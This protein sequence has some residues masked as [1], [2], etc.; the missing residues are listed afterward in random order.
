MWGVNPLAYPLYCRCDR[1]SLLHETQHAFPT[2]RSSSLL[3]LDGLVREVVLLQSAMPAAVF[4]YLLAVQ[5]QREPATVAGMVVS[6]TLI[7]FISIPVLLLY[8]NV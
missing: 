5:Y 8:L 6:P 2:R 1:H 7:S 3:E 4:N